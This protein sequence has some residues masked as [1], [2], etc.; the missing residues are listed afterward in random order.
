MPSAKRRDVLSGLPAQRSEEVRRP[1]GSDV[2]VAA[3]AAAIV[4][5]AALVA[6]QPL[7][8]ALH[9]EWSGNGLYGHGHMLLAMAVWL[10]WRTWRFA[11][12]PRVAPDWRFALPVAG[13]VGL[14]ILFDLLLLNVPRVYLLPPLFAAG[15]GLV[16]GRAA[17]AR[18]APAAFLMYFALPLWEFLNAPLQAMTTAAV[19]RWLAWSGVPAL[20]EGNFVH[21]AAGTFEIAADC[22][23]LRYLLVGAA[24][25]AFWAL[26]FLSDTKRRL[27]LVAA[28]VVLTVL[29]NWIRVYTIILAGHATDMQHYLVAVEHIR[30]GWV[31]FAIALLPLIWLGRRLEQPV[32][33]ARPARER[34]AVDGRAMLR[35]SLVAVVL[36]AL[37][38]LVDA[39]ATA[40]DAGPTAAVPTEPALAGAARPWDPVFV[41]AV[42]AWRVDESGWPPVDVYRATYERQ[43]EDRRLVRYGNGFT[44]SRWRGVASRGIEIELG[45]ETIDAIELEGYVDGERRV[46]W[47]WYLVAGRPAAGPLRAKLL[48]LEGLLRGRRDAA[49]VAVSARCRPDC[50]RARQRLAAVVAAS[51][52]ELKGRD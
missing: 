38:P 2:R 44:G 27:A 10:G 11:P 42:E 41:N 51:A 25:A 14:L 28:A 45:G 43:D 37:P 33:E 52:D 3:L 40:K 30:F 7:W 16:A 1:A 21:L 29:S 19:S 31:V 23:G 39:L 9:H 49:A 6:L 8:A 12:P 47:G 17:A 48:E 22:S 4:S 50:E 26:A 34:S 32:R 5:V 20:I 18:L 36:L 46:I 35:A 13:L 15:A 24:I